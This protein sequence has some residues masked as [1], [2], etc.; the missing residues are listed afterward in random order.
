MLR[1]MNFSEIAEKF[2]L[3]FSKKSQNTRSINK[4]KEEAAEQSSKN[5]SLPTIRMGVSKYNEDKK[6]EKRQQYQN[7]NSQQNVNSRNDTTNYV[8]VRMSDGEIVHIPKSY[9]DYLSKKGTV[10]IL[11]EVDLRRK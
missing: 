3:Y 10:D 6:D 7:L 1:E 8:Y 5:P 2:S 11:K 9:A 4:S